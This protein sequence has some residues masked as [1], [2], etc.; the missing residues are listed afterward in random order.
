MVNVNYK[1]SQE[2]N[3]EIVPKRMFAVMIKTIKLTIFNFV[4]TKIFSL[5]IK[6]EKKS[7]KKLFKLLGFF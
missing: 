6:F 2:T 5:E 3:F 7:C 4:D 1:T